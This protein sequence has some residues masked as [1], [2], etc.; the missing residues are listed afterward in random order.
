MKTTA[1]PDETAIIEALP[2]PV[3]EAQ[4]RGG[5]VVLEVAD[6][7][8]TSNQPIAVRGRRP[9]CD[10]IEFYD[11]RGC[12]G[13]ARIT[14]AGRTMQDLFFS[15][16]KMPRTISLYDQRVQVQAT[17]GALVA[18]HTQK[19]LRR[20]LQTLSPEE[21]KNIWLACCYDELVGGKGLG[22]LRLGL[23]GLYEVLNTI[24]SK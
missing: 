1:K 2:S 14:Q 12:F 22:H 4:L 21:E 7:H 10:V 16:G 19:V 17:G 24:F 15:A 5:A 13:D 8:P 11:A 18:T 23:R 6:R 20:A 9:I 3:P